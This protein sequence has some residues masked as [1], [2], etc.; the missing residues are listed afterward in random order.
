MRDVE[1]T[2]TR[3]SSISNTLRTKRDLFDRNQNA[4][5]LLCR[6]RKE[7]HDYIVIPWKG[8]GVDVVTPSVL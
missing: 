2:E 1:E 6:E 5:L 4:I 7:L 8:H 3:E